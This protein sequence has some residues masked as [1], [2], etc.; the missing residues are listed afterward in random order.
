MGLGAARV[1]PGVAGHRLTSLRHYPTLTMQ[2]T[3]TI[4]TVEV[5]TGGEP[6]HRH[7][8]PAQAARPLYRGAPRMA[9]EHADDIR[10]ALMFSSPV[11]R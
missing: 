8:R 1:F 2:I 3:R 9:V 6:F 11:A 4:S 5:H 7:P 10:Q